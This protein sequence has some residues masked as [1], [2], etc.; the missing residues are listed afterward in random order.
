MWYIPEVERACGGNVELCKPTATLPCYPV[1][2]ADRSISHH[3]SFLALNGYAD[4]D[5]IYK[6]SLEAAVTEKTSPAFLWHTAEDEVVPVQN[7]LVYAASLAKHHIPFELHIYPQG[8]HG[9]SLCNKETW[10]QRS[11]LLM[12]YA[13]NWVEHAL[14]WINE[15][16]FKNK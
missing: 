2:S 7:S 8:P 16:P 15:M 9:L 4:D 6:F 1:I 10:S 11:D 12:P 3:G 5:G 13:E 14:R